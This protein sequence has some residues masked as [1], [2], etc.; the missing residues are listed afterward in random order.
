MPIAC[1]AVFA[2]SLARGLH[3]LASNGS[4]R[5]ARQLS[6]LHVLADNAHPADNYDTV[7]ECNFSNLQTQQRLEEEPAEDKSSIWD[8]T[9]PG[10]LAETGAWKVLRELAMTLSKCVFTTPYCHT[11]CCCC[12]S[13]LSGCLLVT[14]LAA[15]NPTCS[16]W[17]LTYA[18]RIV[19]E[20]HTPCSLS[21]WH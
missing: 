12:T 6:Y 5:H 10:D 2:C 9:P 18:T 14:S 21:Q 3:V 4:V 17:G 16:H 1:K 19:P 11:C 13:P 20:S 7:F 15:L 8:W